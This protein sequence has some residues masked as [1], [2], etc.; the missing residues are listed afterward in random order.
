MSDR[1]PACGAPLEAR[2]NASHNHYFSMLCELWSNLPDEIADNF[3]S[4]EHLRKR[5]LIATGYRDERSFVC[6]SKAEAQR[7]A[8]WVRPDYDFAAISV[9]GAAVVVWTAKS[10]SLRAMG[11]REFEASKTAVLD[12]VA[13]LIGV[14]KGAAE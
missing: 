2:S 13:H 11:K 5:A 9:H 7:L 10:Q 12:W 8:A 6:A 4:I 14:E 1:C 3:P